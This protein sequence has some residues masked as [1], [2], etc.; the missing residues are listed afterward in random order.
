M[1]LYSSLKGNPELLKHYGIIIT[2]QKE[3]GIVEEVKN[4]VVKG[5]IYYLPH[6]SVVRDDKSATPSIFDILLRFHTL[7][8]TFA[9]DI[10]KAFLQ[11]TISEKNKDFLRFLWFDNVYSE[12]PKIVR[13]RFAR[14]LFGVTSSPYLLN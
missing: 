1:S 10:E 12:Q 5:E 7:T 3:L 4:T 2:T 13:N 14:I 11:I 6:H 8:N 9:T